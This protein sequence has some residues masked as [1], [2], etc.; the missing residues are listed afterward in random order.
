MN[1][2]STITSRTNMA[3]LLHITVFLKQL[4]PQ[5]LWLWILL[6]ACTCRSV[7]ISIEHFC[8]FSGHVQYWLHWSWLIITGICSSVSISSTAVS[9]LCACLYY[10]RCVQTVHNHIPAMLSWASISLWIHWAEY[11]VLYLPDWFTVKGRCCRLFSL[12]RHSWFLLWSV[13]FITECI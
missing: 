9:W 6:S 7:P 1:N 11:S 12:L 5:W 8:I 13:W 3:C 2:A 4:L 10:R